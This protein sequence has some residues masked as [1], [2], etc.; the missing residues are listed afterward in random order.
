MYLQGT[1]SG[2]KHYRQHEEEGPVGQLTLK[3][4]F[5]E[6][7][8]GLM[9]DHKDEESKKNKAKQ[10]GTEGTPAKQAHTDTTIKK[11]LEKSNMG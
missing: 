4:S 5:I 1:H 3:T 2:F 11:P 10:T 7:F 6:E 9:R 8:V